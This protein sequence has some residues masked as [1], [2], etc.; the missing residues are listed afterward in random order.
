METMIERIEKS[1]RRMGGKMPWNKELVERLSVDVYESTGRKRP[2]KPYSQIKSHILAEMRRSS[3]PKVRWVKEDG[4]WWLLA[5]EVVSGMT[6]GGGV[7]TGASMGVTTVVTIEPPPDRRVQFKP[8]ADIPEQLHQYIPTGLKYVTGNGEDSL[9]AHALS[10]GKHVLVV[11]DAG[12]GKSTLVEWACQESGQP[13]LSVDVTAGVEEEDFLGFMQLRR[14]ESGGVVTKW[15]DGILPWTMRNGCKL[16][17][18]EVNAMKPALS[19]ALFGAM[20]YKR[21]LTLTRNDHEV[22]MAHPNFQV[23][24]TCNEGYLGTQDLNLAFRDRFKLHIHLSYLPEVREV[25]VVRERSGCTEEAA[26]RLV[27]VAVRMR[28]LFSEDQFSVPISTRAL[29]D[30]GSL[31]AAGYHPYEAARYTVLGRLRS[32]EVVERKSLMEVVESI[33]GRR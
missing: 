31:C 16:L 28:R 5:T 27:S 17:I 29:I 18:E 25:L 13:V 11:G 19:F 9:M 30:W 23:F 32:T 12:C 1:V 15:T 6:E 22:V 7:P 2:T 4:K 20:S 8:T 24:G 14:D 26:R 3:A 33:C 21:T 10:T